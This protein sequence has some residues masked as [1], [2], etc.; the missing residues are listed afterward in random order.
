MI[1]ISKVRVNGE[2]KSFGVTEVKGDFLV[3]QELKKNG[4][5]MKNRRPYLVLKSD[6]DW[7]LD[8]KRQGWGAVVD[9]KGFG[10]D[11]DELEVGNHRVRGS[12][13]YRGVVYHFEASEGHRHYKVKEGDFIS[14][15]NCLYFNHFWSDIHGENDSESVNMLAKIKEASRW[16]TYTKENIT[17]AINTAFNADVIGSTHY[18]RPFALPNNAYRGE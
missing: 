15:D 4:E 18:K 13:L 9:L 16:L 7:T 2:A 5:A 14:V 6:T 10:M 8:R 3:L 17:H 12:F 11:S 1:I